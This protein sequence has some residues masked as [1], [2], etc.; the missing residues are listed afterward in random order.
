MGSGSSALLY[1]FAEAGRLAKGI[2]IELSESRS[3][4][5]EAW[6]RDGDYSMVTNM[7]GDFSGVGVDEAAWDWF[8]VIDNTFTYLYP[9]N[10]LYPTGLLEKAMRSLKAGGY[11]LLDFINY[12]KRE[13]D[14][15]IRHWVA[16]AENDPYAYGLYSH[17]I[18]NG[19]NLSESIFVKRGGGESRKLE[20]SKVYSLQEIST[21]V[22][23][24]GFEVDS[25][26]ATFDE[27]PFVEKESERLVV[28]A[29]KPG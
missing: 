8:V 6:K 29:R 27:Q 5:A 1:A 24:C 22:A 16:Y 14:N 11:L 4:F 17:K 23:S 25:V 15:E 9:E 3:K 21:L 28:L 26:F 20:E 12:A 2:G 18:S 13:P 10:A 7:N 19:I